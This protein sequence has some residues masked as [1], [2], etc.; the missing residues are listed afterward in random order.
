MIPFEEIIDDSCWD[1]QV[2]D[3]YEESEWDFEGPD[4]LD[5]CLNFYDGLSGKDY[6]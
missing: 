6:L 1:D 4:N 3:S 2:E 5:D